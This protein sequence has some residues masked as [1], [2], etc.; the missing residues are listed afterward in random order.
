MKSNPIQL[1]DPA[2]CTYTYVVW[3]QQT[4]EAVI[5]DP[6]DQQ[7]AR[8]LEVLSQY[9]LK[10]RYLLETH[11]HAD[12]ITS[13]SQLIE[14][15]GAVAATPELCTVAPAAIQ[16]QDGDMLS[17]GGQTIQALHT[18]GHTAGSMSFVWQTSEQMHVFTGDTLLIGACGRTD[19][20]SGSAE[21]LYNSITQILFALPADTIVWP[22]HDYKG[23]T[24]STIG[25]EIATNPRLNYPSGGRRTASEFTALMNALNLPKPKRIDEAVPANLVLGRQPLVQ[26]QHKQHEA[27]ADAMTDTKHEIHSADGY[28]G[29]IP[30]AL[31]HTW[32]LTGEAVLVDI[33]T[34]AERAWVGFI[35]GAVA[36]EW[37]MW[38]SMAVNPDFDAQLRAMV[39][40]D[41]KVLM[42]CRSGVRSIAAAKQAQ[43][44]GYQAYNILEGFEGD[45]NGDAHRGLVGGWKYH[46][47]PWRQ[48]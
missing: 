35:E 38:P 4:M 34:H 27:G 10:L 30:P 47:L 20:Q 11:A 21:A 29:D 43:L 24:Q 5:I 37:K 22:A 14:H 48:N 31:A 44:L 16:L 45:P 12:H 18:P 25:A 28:S 1:F 3:D 39:P 40:E 26:S 23:N 41:A 15:T 6:V 33:R 8:D 19:F 7:L 13:S 36:I 46:G 42:L 2:S 17:F 32:R 9:G